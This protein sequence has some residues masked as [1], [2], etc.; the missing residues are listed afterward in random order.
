MFA[1]FSFSQRRH[2]GTR[3][4]PSFRGWAFISYRHSYIPAHHSAT[5]TATGCAFVISFGAIINGQTNTPA[6]LCSRSLIHIHASWRWLAVLYAPFEIQLKHQ[7][8][9][10][11]FAVLKRP[12]YYSR[13]TCGDPCGIGHDRI[14][15]EIRRFHRTSGSLSRWFMRKMTGGR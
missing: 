13:R 4:D 9:Q 12:L 15:N 5:A 7:E 6:I 2:E 8:F 11:R 1:I 10:W 14:S 3:A